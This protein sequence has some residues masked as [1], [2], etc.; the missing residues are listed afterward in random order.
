MNKVSDGFL[1]RDFHQR[2]IEFIN[3]TEDHC[4]EYSK[5]CSRLLLNILIKGTI[6][7]LSKK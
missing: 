4:K 7:V 5:K 3:M 1:G 2:L 6:L